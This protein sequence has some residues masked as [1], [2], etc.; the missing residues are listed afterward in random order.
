[1]PLAPNNSELQN[2]YASGEHLPVP[3]NCLVTGGTGFV[4][5]RLV[6]MLV[7]RGAERVISFD[8][9]PPPESAWTHKNIQYEVG[10]VSD[11]AKLTQLCKGIDCVFH[12]AA[13][14][15]PFHPKE[16]YTRVNY[17]GTLNVIEACK[18][19][20]V[21]K[22]VMSSS[23]STRFTG[24]DIDGLTEDQLPKLPLKSYMQ[25]Y[26][27]SKAQGEIA[28]LQ[29]CC[30]S[31]LTVA[32]APH[33]VYGPRDNLFLPNL[34]ET[35]GNGRLRI[36]AKTSTGWGKNRVCFTHVDNYCHGLIL[37]ERA[38]YPDSPALGKFYIVTDGSTHPFSAGYAN[39]WDSLDEAVIGMGFTSLWSKFKLPYMLLMGLAYVCSALGWLFQTKFK[40]IPFNV[41]VMTMHRWFRIS[42]AERDLK[43]KPLIAFKDGWKE[44][45]VWFRANWLPGFIQRKSNS[46]IIGI[47]AQSQRKI[48]IQAGKRA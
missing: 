17:F 15:G 27:A 33:Q 41:T 31:L 13:A 5:Q 32:I 28:C 16:L 4:G 3:K 46:K 6:E 36:F 8:I 14:V 44:T 34:L 37:G 25:E 38:L 22:L 21:P 39:L 40:L 11:A 48:D 1:M 23:P 26:A 45:I 47:A 18:T 30:P 12:M 2:Q 19:Q 20:K 9:V 7:E 10:D 24:E 35:A 42:A 43:Y 29:A